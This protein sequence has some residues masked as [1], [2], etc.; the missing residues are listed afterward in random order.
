MTAADIRD[1][2][3]DALPSVG[4]FVRVRQ[5]RMAGMTGVVESVA[6]GW[7][8]VRLTAISTTRR[9]RL[10]VLIV[11]ERAPV[12][13]DCTMARRQEGKVAA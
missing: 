5:G 11:E 12:T 2:K 6:D 13:I 4:C 9:F 1:A 3:R 10:G 8:R 7:A